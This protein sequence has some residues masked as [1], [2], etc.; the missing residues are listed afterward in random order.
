M[1][2]ARFL[3][4]PPIRGRGTS[5]RGLKSIQMTLQTSKPLDASTPAAPSKAR[6]LVG[7]LIVIVFF[8]SSLVGADKARAIGMPT[9]GP[10]NEPWHITA[11]DLAVDNLTGEYVARGDVTITKGDRQLT[12]DFVRFNH[13]TMQIAA[14]GN[15]VLSTG[16]DV[17]T[18]NRIEIDLRSEKGTVYDGTLFIQANHF[19]ITGQRIEKI[20]PDA[21]EAQNVS[22]TTCDGET[23]DWKLTARNLEI[24][25]EGYGV[26]RHTSLRLKKIPVLYSPWFMFPV[27][28]QRQSG[29]LTPQMGYATRKGAEF[30]QPL[31]WA[32]NQ[33]SDATF[34]GNYMQERGFKPGFEYRYILSK[35]SK[36]TLMLDGFEDRQIDDGSP[37]A[38]RDWGYGE[39]EYARPNKDRYWFR[40]KHDQ[41]LPFEFTSQ[42]D[43]DIVSDQD[44]LHEFRTGYMGFDDTREYYNDNFYREIDEYNDTVRVNRLNASRTWIQGF[45][46]NAELRYYDDVIKRRWEPEDDTLHKLPVVNFSV[47]RQP[48]GSQLLY[49]DLDSEYT[50]FYR[51]TGTSSHRLD[52]YPRA[53]L[54]FRFFNSVTLEPSVGLRETVWAVDEYDN[55]ADSLERTYD[56]SLFDF[57]LDLSTEF[58]NTWDTA[59]GS[60][61]R[62]K[63]TVKPHIF[64]SYIPH[65]DQ[66][67]FPNFDPV[68]RI[69][70][71]NI[72]TYSLTNFFITRSKTVQAP[73]PESGEDPQATPSQ[74][75][76]RSVCRFLLEQSYDINEAS[77]DNPLEWA[78][79]QERRPFSPVYGEIQFT[80]FEYLT[81][82]A[83]AEWSQYQNDFLTHNIATTLSDKRGDHLYVQHRYTQGS[84]QS[85]YTRLKLKLF[86]PLS[87]YGDY[88]RNL[89]AGANIRMTIGLLY[90]AQ[91]W[92]ADVRYIEESD[93]KSIG[94]M[95]NLNGLGGIRY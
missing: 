74:E 3:T 89:R 24:T 27:K 40:M 78:D 73:P 7:L 87:G 6:S 71:R 11:D 20:G 91:C 35:A 48:L 60:V 64:Y 23:P 86:T 50:H 12:A 25:I 37:D 85:L 43:L 92:S 63:H 62:I 58:F 59:I 29:L 53:Y 84:V 44:Y 28:L 33:S 47:V 15:I 38:T 67:H 77:E 4:A 5:I 80:P 56:R 88:E 41:A 51:T 32:I 16:Q 70:R 31:F 9:L 39:D 13:Q 93:D 8:V 83:D 2:R 57:N 75:R 68:D 90:E 17:I 94:F 65:R 46:L 79:P 61:D 26:A 69:A 1:L 21:Y 14:V 30:I 66:D 55:Q 49:L 42:F 34:Y 82:E 81:L 18:C 95:I 45:N 54:P 72:L 52:L 22:V 36:G 10:A 19:Y 76:Y